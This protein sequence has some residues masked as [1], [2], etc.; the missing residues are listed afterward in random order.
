MSHKLLAIMIRSPSSLPSILRVAARL[1]LFLLHVLIGIAPSAEPALVTPWARHTIDNTS[2]GADGVRLVDVDGDGSL[3]IA[4]PWEEGGQIRLYRFP[5]D[6]DV[7]QP[8]PRVTVGEAASPEDA[9]GADLDQD[10][11]LDVISCHEGQQREIR[12]AFG[13]GG[14]SPFSPAARWVLQPLNHSAKAEA[15]MFAIAGQWDGVGGLDLI[16]GSK[17]EGAGVTLWRAADDPR[18]LSAWRSQTAANG[19]LD[20]VANPL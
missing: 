10:G 3:D 8:W 11:H 12:L 17:N 13:T 2:R 19:G 7:H 16:A 9:F 1:G 15:W 20:H 14:T 18:Q 6:G 4:T 5:V